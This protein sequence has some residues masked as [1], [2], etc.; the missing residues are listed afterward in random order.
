MGAKAEFALRPPQVSDAPRIAE[1]IGDWE[2]VRWLAM[3]PYPYTL[4][5]AE[6]FIAH[7]TSAPQAEGCR[8]EA[9]DIGGQLAGV[10][11]IDLRAVGYNLGFWLGRP[12]WRRGV[13]TA[14]ATELTRD[15]FATS[16]HSMLTSGY[17]SG[18][19]ASWAIQQ[20]LGFQPVGGE[21]K[22]FNR[23]HGTHLLHVETALSRARWDSLDRGHGAARLHRPFTP[24]R[25]HLR[26]H[27]SRRH[28]K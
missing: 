25:P 1:L 28:L 18:N 8:M 27:A 10:V 7:A 14:A 24:T 17:F 4:G 11:S 20:R 16:S 12:Y 3:P 6:A 9:I 15:F 5:D 26:R 23:P 22:L 2:V 21:G 19:E 13:M